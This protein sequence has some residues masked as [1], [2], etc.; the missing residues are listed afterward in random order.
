MND[1]G[2]IEMLR[3]PGKCRESWIDRLPQRV[4]RVIALLSMA[5]LPAMYAWSAFWLTTTVPKFVWGPV[6]FLL[7]GITVGG[8][9]VLYRYVHDR[10]SPRANLDERQRQLQDRA[11]VLAYQ[12]LSGA[13]V[14]ALLGVAIQVLGIGRPIILD[15]GVV[16][17]VALT[18]GVLIPLLPTAALAW[19]EP[20][21]P[22]ET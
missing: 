8:S 22:P 5:G 1:D 11:M 6:T 14:I 16:G 12:V 15:A 19:V 3:N 21:A 13:L 9:F 7:I 10:M 4:R 2:G 17:G 18:T 20:D